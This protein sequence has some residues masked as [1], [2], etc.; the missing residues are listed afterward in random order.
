MKFW[1]CNNLETAIY[2]KADIFPRFG[3]TDLKIDSY[4]SYLYLES[5]LIDYGSKKPNVTG[6]SINNFD[7]SRFDQMEV[8]V[9]N[10]K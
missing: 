4:S 2:N 1:F 7:E 5:K 10:F 9:C 8:F 6:I 3:E